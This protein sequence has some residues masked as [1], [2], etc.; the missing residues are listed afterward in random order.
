MIAKS[1]VCY[2]I[3]TIPYKIHQTPDFFERKHGGY[4]ELLASCWNSDA[5]R[6]NACRVLCHITFGDVKEKGW[7]DV[8]FWP[9]RTKRFTFK[10]ILVLDLLS[11][12]K[13]VCFRHS[14]NHTELK[15]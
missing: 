5:Y 8:T 10:P 14:K 13:N 6:Q 2:V 11:K 9:M 7:A 3:C 1:P 15:N 12:G 4:S